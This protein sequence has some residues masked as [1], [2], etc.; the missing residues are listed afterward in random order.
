MRL[1]ADFKALLWLAGAN[2][3]GRCFFHQRRR[4]RRKCEAALQISGY[5]KEMKDVVC[6]AYRWGPSPDPNYFNACKRRLLLYKRPACV[7]TCSTKTTHCLSA[8]N[9]RSISCL[10]ALHVFFFAQDSFIK[11][12]KVILEFLIRIIKNS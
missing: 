12:W 3:F 5:N 10:R 11:I 4:E 6:V 1:K 7:S 9:F 2:L 8:I